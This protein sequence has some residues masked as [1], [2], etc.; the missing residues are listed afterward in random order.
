VK[1]TGKGKRREFNNTVFIYSQFKKGCPLQTLNLKTLSAQS[2]MG[3]QVSS[4]VVEY[5]R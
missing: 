4:I 1:G 2:L 5:C 3:A